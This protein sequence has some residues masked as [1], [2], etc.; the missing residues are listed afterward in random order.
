MVGSSAVTRPPAGCLTSIPSAP[1]MCSYGSRLET[2]MNLQSFRYCVMSTIGVEEPAT[3][4]PGPERL[5]ARDWLT[6]SR[7]I[8]LALLQLLLP[9]QRGEHHRDARTDAHRLRGRMDGRST[10]LQRG[11]RL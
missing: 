6:T 1:R 4:M 8:R 7:R 2:R 3:A 5:G 9:Q 10:L 11:W